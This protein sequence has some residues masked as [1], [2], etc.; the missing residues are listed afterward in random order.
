VTGA[1]APVIPP[2]FGVQAPP[3]ERDTMR[4]CKC[5]RALAKHLP[6]SLFMEM[7][8]SHVPLRRP[9]AVAISIAHAVLVGSVLACGSDKPI[10]AGT[11]TT[12]RPQAVRP[13]APGDPNCPRTGTW[14]PCGLVDRVAKAGL[15]I[16]ATNDSARVAFLPVPGVRYRVALTDTLLAFFFAD[17]A[18]LAK[19]IAPLDSLRIAPRSDSLSPWPALP[20]VIRSGNLLALYFAESDRQIERLRLAITAGAPAVSPP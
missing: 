13:P 12:G 8:R 5:V 11:V 16:K 18:A 15:S 6:L 4:A 14:Q 1:C 17:S 2:P 20:S 3:T 7:T 10:P 19:A 9:L